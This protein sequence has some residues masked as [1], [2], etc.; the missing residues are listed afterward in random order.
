[1]NFLPLPMP[2]SYIDCVTYSTARWIRE[3]PHLDFKYEFIILKRKC[4]L[5]CYPLSSWDERFLDQIIDVFGRAALISGLG[6]GLGETFA[7]VLK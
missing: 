7:I 2:R 5:S 3:D 1:M 6:W 4:Y